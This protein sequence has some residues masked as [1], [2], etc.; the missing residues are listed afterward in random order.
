V[1]DDCLYFKDSEL[2]EKTAKFCELPEE[3]KHRQ[4]VRMR[5]TAEKSFDIESINIKS[6]E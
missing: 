4:R 5:A 1:P 6:E 3:A 2:I